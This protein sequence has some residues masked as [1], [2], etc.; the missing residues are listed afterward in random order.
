MGSLQTVESG[1]SWSAT[2]AA[3]PTRGRRPSI[4]PRTDLPGVCSGHVLGVR[5]P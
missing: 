5:G 3:R 2:S 1:R 4:R